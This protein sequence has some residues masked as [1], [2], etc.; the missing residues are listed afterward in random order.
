MNLSP[1]VLDTLKR[2]SITGNRTT[3]P[4]LD[5][6]LYVKVNEALECLGG[7]WDRKAKAHVWDCDPNDP[8]A[9]AVATGEVTD[10]K[11]EFQ[12][13]ETPHDVA[14]RMA[15]K[16]DIQPEHRVLEPSAGR[17]S[18]LNGITV[19]CKEICAVELNPNMVALL[20]QTQGSNVDVQWADFLML[21]GSLGSFDRIIMNPPF[22]KH[23][24]IMHV[25]HAYRMLKPRG[26]LV[27][28]TSPGW[29]FRNDVLHADFRTAMEAF[30][31]EVEPL[32]AGTFKSSGTMVNTVMLTIDKE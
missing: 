4:M 13:F 6:K 22:N 12:F 29:T 19:P 10:W 26:R 16:A 25:T 32:P 30:G 9:E 21:D 18:L 3:M 8:I 20:K 23:Q 14:L 27:A 24:D 1:E 7:K 5:R 2:I 11:K 28:I 15:D 31:A 17:G